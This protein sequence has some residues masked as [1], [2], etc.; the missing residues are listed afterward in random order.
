MA[1]ARQPSSVGR[2]P[3]DDGE[4]L[5]ELAFAKRLIPLQLEMVAPLQENCMTSIWNLEGIALCPADC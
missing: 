1:I 4:G 2:Y 3:A 5:W